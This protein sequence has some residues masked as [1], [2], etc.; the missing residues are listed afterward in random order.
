MCSC[1][2]CEACA[3]C[4]LW[5][6]GCGDGRHLRSLTFDA[7]FTGVPA[8]DESHGNRAAAIATCL[9]AAGTGG[10]LV[11]LTARVYPTL[12]TEWLPAL[13]ALRR[14]TLTA[15]YGLFISSA[16]YRLSALQSLHLSGRV[17]FAL[18]A[19]LPTS[20]TRLFVE[21]M[22]ATTMPAQARGLGW[23]AILPTCSPQ[24]LWACYHLNLLLNLPTITSLHP[25]ACDCSMPRAGCPVWIC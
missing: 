5:L 13:C 9:T 7:E 11:Q 6:P 8:G 3:R 22:H 18:D 25:S 4:T 2:A 21:D 15:P 19:S 16:V 14:L 12:D 20:I 10:G 23:C 24:P 17:R 1:P